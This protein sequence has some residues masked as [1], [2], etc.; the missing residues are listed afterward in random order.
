M[1]PTRYACEKR[2]SAVPRRRGPN[3]ST[4]TL[5]STAECAPAE[6]VIAG[7]MADVTKYRNTMF[8][9]TDERCFSSQRTDGAYWWHRLIVALAAGRRGLAQ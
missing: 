2:P 6:G 5:V 7:C 1:T 3:A 4:T 9:Q 8:Q